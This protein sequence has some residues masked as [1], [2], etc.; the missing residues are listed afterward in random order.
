LLL[1]LNIVSYQNDEVGRVVDDII[2]KILGPWFKA[3][4]KP[5]FGAQAFTIEGNVSEKHKLL[6]SKPSTQK[7]RFKLY[8]HSKGLLRDKHKPL[9]S[10]L[11]F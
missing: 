9:R 6:S 5:S 4:C 11:S 7:S 10:K 1:K 8:D 3:T 2:F